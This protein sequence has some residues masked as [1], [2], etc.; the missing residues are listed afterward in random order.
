VTSGSQSVVYGELA[1]EFAPFLGP[2]DTERSALARFS[3]RRKV[4]PRLAEFDAEIAELDGRA[5]SAGQELVEARQA[6]NDAPQRDAA[7]YA[8]WIAE[9]EH[10]EPPEPTKPQLEQR[11]AALENRH[12][13]LLRA[14]EEK[15]TDKGKYVEKHRK[16]LVKEA[17]RL[18]A[19][20][21]E[22]YEQT[23][24]AA[25][26]ARDELS[27]LRAAELW[28]ATFP[29]PSSTATI[30]VAVAGGKRSV[31]EK[32]GIHN[33]VVPARVF[34]L[35]HA[36]AEWLATAVNRDQRK[37]MGIAPTDGEALWEGDFREQQEADRR[38]ALDLHKR[39]W[40]L[41]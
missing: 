30:P 36:D 20:A 37:A 31:L 32:A 23:I 3:P 27:E 33:S 39:R 15:A 29:D 34:E 7:L 14:A 18:A 8:Q 13:A 1:R 41:S 24:D 35:L 26:Q 5:A 21:R 12:N 11:V 22:R 17:E 2:L 10:G 40:G 38:E 9:G 28:A 16:G 4:W 25:A 19:Q 6:L